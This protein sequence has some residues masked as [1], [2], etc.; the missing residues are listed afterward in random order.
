MGICNMLDETGP[1][2]MAEDN[3][4]DI[5]ITRRAWMKGN[6]RNPLHVVNNGEEVLDFLYKRNGHENAPTP[7]LMLLDLK[8]PKMGGFEVIQHVKQNEDLKSIPIIVLTSSE[9]TV[10]ICE[11]YKAGANSYIVKP[12]N[13]D[14]FIKSILDVK[15]YW[16]NICKMPHVP[17]PSSGITQI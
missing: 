15:N 12:V 4:N 11:A 17:K 14:K 16:L 6:I 5:L 3:E 13:F 7:L 9:R 1:I 10:D 8:M 2:L